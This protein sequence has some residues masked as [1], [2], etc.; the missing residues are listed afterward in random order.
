VLLDDNFDVMPLIVDEGRRVLA[1]VERVSVF[2]LTKTVWACTL[3]LIVGVSGMPYPL[4]SSQATLIGF[5]AIGAPAF[6]LSF[7]REAPRA[8]QGIFHR[9]VRRSLPAGVVSAGV[10]ASVFA[11][12]HY[13]LHR[14]TAEARSGTTLALTL[15]SLTIVALNLGSHPGKWRALP[16]SLVALGL[17]IIGI[18]A[19]RTWFSI[20]TQ[21]RGGGITIVLAAAAGSAL[22]TAIDLF[23]RRRHHPAT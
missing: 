11:I 18:P 4:F 10:G 6:L 7:R 23:V 21:T 19:L 17:M 15:V 13:Q 12:I 14:T 22:I 9:V 8:R 20:E 5:L 2:F 1:N 16:V 3:S